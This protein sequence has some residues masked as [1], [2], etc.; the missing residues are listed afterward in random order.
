MGKKQKE[1]KVEE[2]KTEET[3]P[4]QDPAAARTI[5]DG[6]GNKQVLAEWY[7]IRG[8]S[9]AAFY[10]YL[11]TRPFIEVAQLMPLFQQLMDIKPVTVDETVP[12]G[13]VDENGKVTMPDEVEAGTMAQ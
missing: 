3:S 9:V 5:V 11:A 4:V 2:T 7:G 10:V 8:E 12:T 13:T 6:Q 1:V